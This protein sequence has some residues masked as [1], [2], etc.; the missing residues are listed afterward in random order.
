MECGIEVEKDLIMFL[1]KLKDNETKGRP[2][3]SQPNIN[4][5]VGEGNKNAC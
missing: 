5:D 4:K 1:T 2:S 3:N